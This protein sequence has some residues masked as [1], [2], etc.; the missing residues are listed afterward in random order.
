MNY[1]S[2]EEYFNSLGISEKE[3]NVLIGYMSSLAEISISF[4]NDKKKQHGKLCNL[5]EGINQTSRR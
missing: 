3:A 5:D 2:H 1:K 4:L